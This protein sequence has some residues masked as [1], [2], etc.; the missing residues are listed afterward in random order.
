[1]LFLRKNVRCTAQKPLLQE[2]L[3]YLHGTDEVV[4]PAVVDVDH[5]IVQAVFPAQENYLQGSKAQGSYTAALSSQFSHSP[6]PVLALPSSKST[7]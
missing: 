1:M 5:G 6:S 2:H 3:S 4:H 7:T